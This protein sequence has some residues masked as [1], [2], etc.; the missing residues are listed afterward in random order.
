MPVVYEYLGIKIGFFSNEHEPIH[1]HAVY[2]GAMMKVI[3]YVQDGVVH[4]VAYK[5]EKGDFNKAKLSDL[6]IFISKNKNALYYA[7]V[8]FFQNQTNE[9]LK[10]KTIVITKRI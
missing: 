3:L 1:V 4:R 8:Q 2:N 9:N 10:I 7:W 5:T 6:K